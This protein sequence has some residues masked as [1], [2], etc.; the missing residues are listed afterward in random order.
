MLYRLRSAPPA[1]FPE[2]RLAPGTI[3]AVHAHFDQLVTFQTT[4]DFREDRGRQSG[5]ADQYDRI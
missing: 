5:S 1:N 2:D 3:R 4:L